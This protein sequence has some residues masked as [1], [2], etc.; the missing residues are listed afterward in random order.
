[1]RDTIRISVIVPVFNIAPYIT[2]CIESLQRQ[3][4]TDMEIILVDDGS[5]DESGKICDDFS[6]KD[7]RIIVIHKE[8]EGL[9]S[10]RNAG[11]DVARGKYLGFVDGDDW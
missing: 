2:K 3:T 10:A 11:I 4:F 5:T 6:K 1:M 9:S 8:N 7:A